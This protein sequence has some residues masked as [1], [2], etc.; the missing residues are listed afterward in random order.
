M[1]TLAGAAIAF[2]VLGVATPA[3]ARGQTD[4]RPRRASSS[5]DRAYQ[6][7]YDEGYRSG[8]DHGIE[9]NR[10]SG[11][12]NPKD[13]KEYQK[14]DVGYDDS[15][16]SREQY[17]LGYRAGFEQGFEDGFGGQQ[18]GA[19]PGVDRV[20]VQ[21]GG[22]PVLRRDGGQGVDPNAGP[23]RVGADTVMV[24]ELE[25]PITTRYSREG[26]RFTAKVLEPAPLA[27]SVVEGYIGKLERPGKVQGKGEVVL[28]FQQITF[29]DGVVEPLQAQVEEVI[30]Y[31]RGVPR[32]G[33]NGPL[34]RAPWEWGKKGDRNDDIDAQAGDEGQ[35]EGESSKTRDA[36][37]IGGAAAAGAVIGGVLGGGGGAAVG[38][39][40]GGVTGGG[41]VAASRGHE[42]DLEPGA[43][44]RIRT[45]QGVSY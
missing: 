30:G 9:A 8:Y 18:Y 33:G 43:R 12:N 7:A 27:G 25:S 40:I 32:A 13:Y 44:L 34:N 16:G 17:T 31:E 6:I 3:P 14:G 5:Y 23:A 20:P 36:A 35:I 45:G 24:I 1:K 19:R 28:E 21:S 38:A 2:I 39:V 37:T 10:S 41:A 15:I 26:D 11:S 42:I 4:E 22:G 29:P